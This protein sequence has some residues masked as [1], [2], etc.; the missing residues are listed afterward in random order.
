ME[1][2]AGEL[3][4]I[5]E[6][7]ILQHKTL[8]NVEQK[9]LHS[10]ISQDL[11]GLESLISQS[12][13]ILKDIEHSEKTRLVIVEELCGTDKA[14]I[15]EIG[16]KLSEKKNAELTARAGSLKTLMLEQKELNQRIEYLLKDSLDIIN[17]SVSLFSGAGPNGRTYSGEGEERSPDEKPASLV[18]DIKA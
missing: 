11:Q 2:K 1:S 17:F 3:V 13:K 16:Q 15:T 9:K 18:L 10:I 14:T 7:L 6:K 5:L 4:T 8:L 12:K